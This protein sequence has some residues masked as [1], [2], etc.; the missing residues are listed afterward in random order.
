[1]TKITTTSPTVATKT[2]AAPKRCSASTPTIVAETSWQIS[3]SSSSGLRN[4]SGS[5]ESF[6]SA[7]APRRPWSRSERALDLF[8][9]TSEVSASAKKPESISS[10]KTL[11]DM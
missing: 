7:F 2:P 6:T 11:I 9:R 4:F 8:M 10:T 3:T 1:M 5:S